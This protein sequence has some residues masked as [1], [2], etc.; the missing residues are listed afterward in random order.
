MGSATG[1]DLHVDQFL[2]Q[3]AINYRPTGMI[4]DQIAPIIPVAKETDS[5]PIFNRGEVFAIEKTQRSRGTSANRVTRSVSSGQYAVKNYALAYDIPVEDRANMDAALQFELEAGS[6]RYLTDKLMLD[7]DRRTLNA[8]VTGVS[9]TFLTGSSWT[10][11]S[12]PG[13][14][15]SSIWRMQ[16][17]V[18]RV[19]AQKPNSLIFGWQAWN[20]ARRNANMRN[21]VL[22]LNNGGGSVTRQ[23]VAAAFEVERLLVANAFYNPANENQAAAF[24]NYFPS[25][26]VL[27]YYAPLSPSREAPSFMY[28]FRWT[29]PELGQP[30]AAIRHE[31]DTRNRLDGVEVQYYQDERV[32][33]SE[34]GVL[35]AGCGSAQA[36]GLT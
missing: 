12:N 16:E 6:I 24:S 35:L 17:Q 10:A 29:A 4:A 11:G 23:A 27:A 15:V 3:V 13:D 1:R 30:F 26:A 28:S 34:Y 31:F 5:Y 21:F 18:Q 8:A 9:T 19:T 33:G 36:N 22:G 7:Y 14:P 20:F 25:D 2:S 32:T